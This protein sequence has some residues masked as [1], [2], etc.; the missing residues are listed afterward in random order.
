MNRDVVISACVCFATIVLGVV[1]FI[2]PQTGRFQLLDDEIAAKRNDIAT[3]QAYINDFPRLLKQEQAKISVLQ[4]VQAMGSDTDVE[5]AFFSGLDQIVR[6]D[7]LGVRPITLEPA[8]SPV[9]VTAPVPTAKLAPGSTPSPAPVGQP[10][11]Q[12]FKNSGSIEIV[13]NWAS[14]LHG[15]SDLSGLPVLLEVQGVTLTRD[16]SDHGN[17]QNPMLDARVA[18]TLYRI[19]DLPAAV[20]APVVPP[21]ATAPAGA[22]VPGAPV[23]K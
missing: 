19:A 10:T 4:S 20:P 16:S 6:R 7:H 18:F 1:L 17:P 3:D 12:F 14:I 15:V 21:A 11:G 13:G 2:M 22:T 8:F 9:A 5:Q 23:T